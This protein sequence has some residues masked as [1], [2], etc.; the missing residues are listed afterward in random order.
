MATNE[1]VIVL[2]VFLPQS[3]NGHHDRRP[4]QF[5]ICAIHHQGALST[6]HKIRYDIKKKMYKIFEGMHV[7]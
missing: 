5:A 7:L 4:P 6:I 2:D 1:A 3:W